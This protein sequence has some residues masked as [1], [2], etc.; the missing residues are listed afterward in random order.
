MF[1]NVSEFHRGVRLVSDYVSF[2]QDVTVQVF[3]STIRVLGGLVSAHLFLTDTT[4]HSDASLPGYDNELLDMARDLTDRLSDALQ[5]SPSGLPY[6]RV[7]LRYGV[8][9]RAE[10]MYE[11]CLAGAGSLILEFGLVSRLT[12]DPIYERL[13]KRAVKNL[14]GRRAN[15]TGL[16]GNTIDVR[17]GEWI[18][19]TSGAFDHVSRVC[20]HGCNEA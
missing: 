1:G 15:G 16:L 7:N 3:E 5:G 2:D 18:D 4:L 9:L 17:H 11:T 14:W 12:G 6:P 20:R 10:K 19:N 13:A 8:Q